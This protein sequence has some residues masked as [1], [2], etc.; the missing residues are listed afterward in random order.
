MT[1]NFRSHDAGC[2][3]ASAPTVTINNTPVIVYSAALAP[4]STGLYQIAIQVPTT[5]A[6]GDW[7]ILASI[8]YVTSASGI[9]LAI[10]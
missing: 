3:T 4:D 2:P 8:G 7:P 1:T 9:V 10:A 5:P 6:A